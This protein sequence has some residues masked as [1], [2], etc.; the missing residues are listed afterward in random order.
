MIKLIALMVF[1]AA[2]LCSAGAQST[3]TSTPTGTALPDGAGKPVI[4]RACGSC[5]TLNIVTSKRASSDEWTHVVNEMVSRGAD[6][7][8]NEMDT[9]IQYLT[10]NFGP[11]GS[12]SESPSSPGTTKSPSLNNGVPPASPDTSSSPASIQPNGNKTSN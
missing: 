11:T 6:L 8:D 2:S 10:T 5:H 7:S 1:T 9:L 12:K 3:H 4:Q